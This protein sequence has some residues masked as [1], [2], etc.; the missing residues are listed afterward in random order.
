MLGHID[1]RFE[2]RQA[3]GRTQQSISD[4]SAHEPNYT[5]FTRWLLWYAAG[6]RPL[7][8]LLL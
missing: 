6:R 1:K 2:D 4:P 5:A 3:Y 7:R 8:A